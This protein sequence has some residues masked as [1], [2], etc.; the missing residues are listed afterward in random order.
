MERELEEV[1]EFYSAL[2]EDEGVRLSCRGS[3]AMMGD[4]VLFR[5][6][7]GNLISNA[8]KYTPRGGE[9]VVSAF[10][11][12]QEC[13]QVEVS[14]NG[15]GI[16]AEDLP[17][18]FDRFFRVPGL[19]QMDPQGSGLGLSIVKAIMDLHGG[20]V[21]ITSRPGSGTSARLSFPAATQPVTG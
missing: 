17:K 2:A 4:A 10:R 11:A 14:D 9:V 8:L 7:V 21:D 5:R 16:P 3:A 18:I 6:A 1:V 15:Y 20:R 13:V 12:E 19:R